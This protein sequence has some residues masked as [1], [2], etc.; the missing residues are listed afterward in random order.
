MVAPAIVARDATP[1]EEVE[2][3]AETAQ[4][5][6]EEETSAQTDPMPRVARK[7]SPA[8]PARYQPDAVV[9]YDARGK[10][11]IEAL[12]VGPDGV[13]RYRV[14]RDVRPEARLP[15]EA[16]VTAAPTL[17]AK[18]KVSS[19]EDAAEREADAVADRVMTLPATVPAKCDDCEHEED[20][21]RKTGSELARAPGLVQTLQ[22]SAA[23]IQRE[24][25]TETPRTPARA[26]QLALFAQVARW[27][28][29]GLLHET[30]LPA[31]VAPFPEF[32][33]T[34]EE[35][36]HWRTA[37][38]FTGVTG[39]KELLEKSV[40]AQAARTAGAASAGGGILAR[41]L[42]RGGIILALILP[43]GPLNE[44]E[45]R[46]ELTG[47]FLAGFEQRWWSALS[48]SQ[49]QYLMELKQR[50]DDRVFGE[51]RLIEETQERLEDQT[52][53]SAER[54][55]EPEPTCERRDV[56]RRGGHREHDAYATRVTGSPRDH[57]VFSRA[58]GFHVN[59]DGRTGPVLVWE[60]K[61]RYWWWDLPKYQGLKA[62]VLGRFEDQRE[63]GIGIARA[64]G[65]KHKWAVQNPALAL[66]LRRLWGSEPE[67]DVIR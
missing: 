54:E 7:E 53:V 50:E 32:Q 19:P 21:K 36:E 46:N 48:Q 4:P 29:S 61:V 44:D 60:C 41:I 39:T 42:L 2:R 63:R 47:D 13:Q 67:I 23:H 33:I 65:L 43:S 25:R 31:G 64:C 15:P 17:Q 55:S 49:K 66:D 56:P 18:L 14:T 52:A 9:A 62:Q 20:S 28:E 34:T 30:R 26:R 57:F 40:A 16:P 5:I 1:A 10:K 45:E 24:P 58:T 8:P 22:Q 35:A 51:A 12:P 27:M 3:Q 37:L 59:Y 38:L 6:I 11:T